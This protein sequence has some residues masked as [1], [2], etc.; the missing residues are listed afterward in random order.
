MHLALRLL[1]AIVFLAPVSTVA[2]SIEDT[3]SQGRATKWHFVVPPNEQPIEEFQARKRHDGDVLVSYRACCGKDRWR[4]VTFFSGE[5]FR[6]VE[7]AFG[8]GFP[9]PDAKSRYTTS[10]HKTIATY[11][12]HA[13]MRQGCYAGLDATVSVFDESPSNSG[14]PAAIEKTVLLLLEKPGDFTSRQ[15]CN[16]T[17]RFK[18]WVVSLGGIVVPLEDRTFL[19]LDRAY[20][21]ALRMTE[22]LRTQSPL[23]GDRIFIV[24]TEEFRRRFGAQYG[25]REEGLRDFKSLH[26]DLRRWVLQLREGKK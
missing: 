13:V 21:V 11:G 12:T 6:S 4:H 3:T 8:G 18:Y 10:E 7:A 19:L 20:G 15:G 17:R 5:R 26:R 16:E 24:D 2:T 23:L 22:D 14:Q 9:P 1:L 25:S